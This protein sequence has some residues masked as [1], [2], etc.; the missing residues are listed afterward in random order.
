M[1]IRTIY[2]YDIA[3]SITSMTD[4]YKTI[5]DA[6][7]ILSTAGFAVKQ[8]VLSGSEGASQGIN[9]KTQPEKVLGI[10]WGI[11]SN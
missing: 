2:V 9:L 10:S 1:I 5:I 11:E 8:W 3:Q 4:A 7:C 6:E